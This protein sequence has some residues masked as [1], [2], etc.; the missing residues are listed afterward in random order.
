[1]RVRA[2]KSFV[3]GKYGRHS[4]GDKFEIP[5]GADWVKAGLVEIVEGDDIETASMQP[6]EKAV[7][8]KTNTP[9]KTKATK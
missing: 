7:V 8:K 9:R 4:K 2:L 3:D 5:S 6:P 1:M